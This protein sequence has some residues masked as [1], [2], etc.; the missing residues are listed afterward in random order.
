MYRRNSYD[1][2][3]CASTSLDIEGAFDAASWVIM[4]E[5]DKLP[6]AS[7]L[8]N[9]ISNL[10]IGF[11]FAGGIKWFLLFQGR[12][13][14]SCFGPLFWLLIPDFVLKEYSLIF[15]YIVSYADDFVIPR[16]GNNRRQ[17]EE[18]KNTSITLFKNICDKY[19]LRLN[20][21][22]CEA[23]LFGK[24]QLENRRPIFKLD[25]NSIPVKGNIIFALPLMVM[26]HS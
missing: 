10:F 4:L 21:G 16:R 6:I 26:S 24:Q 23:I 7:Y 13:Q 25:T 19:G 22:K 20:V 15:G 14:G 2:K 9:F 17:L 11:F 8:K 1:F 12:W 5:I 3:Y 18:N